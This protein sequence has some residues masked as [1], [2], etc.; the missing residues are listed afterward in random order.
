MVTLNDNL[1]KHCSKI[2][3]LTS[4]NI[5][6]LTSQNIFECQLKMEELKNEILNKDINFSPM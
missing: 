2:K 6:F 4:S 5:I 1:I 3:I